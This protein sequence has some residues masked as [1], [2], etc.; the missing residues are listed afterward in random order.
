LTWLGFGRLGP[1]IWVSPRDLR[2]KVT[3]EAEALGILDRI[4]F[5]VGQYLGF[6]QARELVD[7][8]WDMKQLNQAYLD[9]IERHRPAWQKL[10]NQTNDE[11]IRAR[12][13]FIQRFL[14]VHEYRSFP[15]VDP[16]LP[17]ELLSH[18][19]LGNEAI[20]LFQNYVALLAPKAN[21]YVDQVL[22]AE[23]NG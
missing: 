9:F 17:P 20:N 7:R 3:Q 10:V 5:F 11:A 2:Q 16:N 23:P 4:D 8:C 15:Y 19:W 13:I 12:D 18:D 1:A 22:G 14:L 6:S 21:E